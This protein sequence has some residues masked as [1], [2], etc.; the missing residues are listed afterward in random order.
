[1]KTARIKITGASPIAFG[2][3]H[4]TPKL[5]S[6]RSNDAAYEE[7]TWIEKCHFNK[8]GEVVIQPFAIKNMLSDIAQFLSVKTKGNATFTKHFQAGIMVVDAMPIGIKREDVKGQWI[9]VPSDGKRGGTKRV[10]KCFPMIQDWG[11]E[12]DVLVLDEIITK[13]VLQEHLEEAGKFIGLGSL[14]PR[15]N[16]ICGRFSAEVLSFK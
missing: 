8:D 1:M 5:E 2:R 7:R 6:E 13:K 3:Y 14:R 16:G 11:G 12:V 15:N 10:P 4:Q 9:H